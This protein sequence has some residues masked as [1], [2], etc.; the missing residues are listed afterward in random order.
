M[1][2]EGM[3]SVL[4]ERNV[5]I[6]DPSSF[7]VK[8]YIDQFLKDYDLER[9]SF[10]PVGNPEW[11]LDFEKEY[12]EDGSAY[13][14]VSSVDDQGYHQLLSENEKG[15]MLGHIN[16]VRTYIEENYGDLMMLTSWRK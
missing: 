5:A 16:E 3:L 6:F 8:T 2:K 14:T 12:R 1:E 13:C 7:D 4:T 10:V 15:Y 11:S 9:T